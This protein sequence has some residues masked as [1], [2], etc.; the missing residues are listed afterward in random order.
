MSASFHVKQ[1]ACMLISEFGLA[2]APADKTLYN[3]A[4]AIHPAEVF[5]AISHRI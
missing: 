1:Q 2:K 5:H 3:L 4:S